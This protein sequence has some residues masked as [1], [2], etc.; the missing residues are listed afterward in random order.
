MVEWTPCCVWCLHWWIHPVL[1]SRCLFI[2]H[3]QSCIIS[4]Y[5]LFFFQLLHVVMFHTFIHL[6][7]FFSNDY[8]KYM[9]PTHKNSRLF[10]Q[11]LFCVHYYIS[12]V[13][14][15]T[16]CECLHKSFHLV[17]RSLHRLFHFYIS[18]YYIRHG[19]QHKRN[20]M[21]RVNGKNTVST[22]MVQNGFFSIS[23]CL[24]NMKIYR[25]GDTVAT[26]AHIKLFNGL[27]HY[28]SFI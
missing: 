17:D 27:K 4:V 1:V 19:L 24:V 5:H 8:T 28:V 26:K 23:E 11:P 12:L 25:W 14:I 20:L 21:K 2:L 15:F 13:L 7:S 16:Q 3:L 18:S 10:S 6:S 22:F 9:H